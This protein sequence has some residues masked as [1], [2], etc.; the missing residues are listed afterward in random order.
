MRVAV[1]CAR[2]KT[3]TIK[4]GILVGMLYGLIQEDDV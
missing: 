4:L 1:Y 3:E 2:M